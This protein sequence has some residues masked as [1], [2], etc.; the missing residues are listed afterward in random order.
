MQGVS[1]ALC[2]WGEIAPLT[3]IFCWT[4]KICP[5]PTRGEGWRALRDF[6]RRMAK[7]TLHA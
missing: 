7:P 1:T 3:L 6:L 5:S 2:G 4:Q